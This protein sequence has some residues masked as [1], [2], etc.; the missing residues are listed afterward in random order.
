MNNK[1]AFTLAELLVAMLMFALLAVVLIPNVAIN[2]EKELFSVQLKKVQN[3]IQQAMLIMMSQNQGTLSLLCSGA[4]SSKCFVGEI[5]EKLEKAVMYSHSDYTNCNVA[6]KSDKKSEQGQACA[7]ME[8]QP[9]YMNKGE[10]TLDVIDKTKF[11]AINLKNGATAS[12]IFDPAC[13][14]A[15]VDTV[16]YSEVE[17]D[18]KPRICGYME[19]DVNAAKVPNTVGKD[20]H[21]FW[22]VDQDGIVPFGEIDNFTCGTYRTSG[23]IETKPQNETNLVTQ[24]G[25]TYRVLQKKKADFY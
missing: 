20:I 11:Q 7:Y 14:G 17:A 18:F 16:L 1:K 3:D 19:V 4:D 23:G 2:A 12:V 8:R 24:L 10:V 15:S 6:D 22:I 9:M 21:Y 25:C 5:E 13:A